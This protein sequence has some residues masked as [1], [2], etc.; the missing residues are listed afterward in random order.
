MALVGDA[1]LG[2]QRFG[3]LDR[4]S[5]A[6]PEH[7]S[8]RLDNVIEHAHVRPQ[9]EILEDEANLAAQPVDLAIVGSHQFAVARRLELERFTGHQDF[10]LVRVFQQIDAAQQSRLAGAGRAEDGN[11]GAIVGS[12]RNAFEYVQCTVTL[13]QVADFQRGRGLGHVR[14]SSIRGT[15]C[16]GDVDSKPKASTVQTA[17]LNAWL[18]LGLLVASPKGAVARSVRRAGGAV[19]GR[20]GASFAKARKASMRQVRDNAM[21]GGYTKVA[22]GCRSTHAKVAP[23]GCTV[24]VRWC[25]RG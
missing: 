1:N 4:F 14:S 16:Q 3:H 22:L 7:A 13:V 12:Q 8:R 5:P 17:R 19:K 25:Y 2:Q 18:G 11:H 21:R 6:L 24:F 9:V 20:D 15:A 10:P 23:S